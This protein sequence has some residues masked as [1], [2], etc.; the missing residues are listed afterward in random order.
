ML[1]EY[2]GRIFQNAKRI[3][4][5]SGVEVTKPRMIG[6]QQHCANVEASNWHK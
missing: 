5:N 2:S 6:R 3:A 4:E 1:D